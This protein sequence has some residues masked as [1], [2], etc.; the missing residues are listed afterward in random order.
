MSFDIQLDRGTHDLVIDPGTGDIQLLN[1]ARRVAQQIKITLLAFLGE[2]FLD[3]SFGVPYLEEV[4]IKNPRGGTLQAVFRAKIIAV[5]GV[6]RIRRLQFE[7]DRASRG[8]TVIFEAE[9]SEGLTGPQNIV[10]SLRRSA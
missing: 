7:L 6:L 1:G 5:P 10:L 9:T 4:M 8:L 2:W 3:T